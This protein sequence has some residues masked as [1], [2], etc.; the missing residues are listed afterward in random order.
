MKACAYCVATPSQPASAAKPGA[1]K[2]NWMVTHSDQLRAP[3]ACSTPKV[4]CII[5]TMTMPNPLA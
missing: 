3:A 2:A 1:L 4:E 5:T